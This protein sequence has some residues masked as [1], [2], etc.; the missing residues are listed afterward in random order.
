MKGKITMTVTIGLVCFILVAVMFMQFK[1]ISHTDITAL[2]NMQETELRT[3][4]TSWKATYEDVAT[5]IEATELTIAEYRSKIE[6]NQQASELLDKELLQANAILGKIDVSGP[7]IIVTLTDT[8][9]RAVTP[10]DLKTLVNELKIAGAEAISINDERLVYSSYVSY[11]NDIY[12]TVNGRRQL[13]PYVVKAIGNPTYLE[14]GLSAKNVGYIDS[15]KAEGLNIV[16]QRQDS[17]TIPKYNGNDLD[18][19]YTK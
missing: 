16:L 15:R 18:F 2:E 6:N 19:E 5:K 9:D 17:I 1:T 12:V 7:G 4:I 11:I 8:E 14:S 3:E 10:E 13:S